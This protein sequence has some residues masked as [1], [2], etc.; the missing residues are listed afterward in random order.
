[1]ADSLKMSV[2]GA[3]VLIPRRWGREVVLLVL[4]SYPMKSPDMKLMML[5]SNKLAHWN[6]LDFVGYFLISANASNESSRYP[7]SHNTPQFD[8]NRQ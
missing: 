4:V 6:I 8:L 3:F 5:N 2:S 1:M 7:L